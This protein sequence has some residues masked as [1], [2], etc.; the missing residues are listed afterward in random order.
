MI[1]VILGGITGYLAYDRLWANNPVWNSALEPS[2]ASSAVD[3]VS[4][5]CSTDG[6]LGTPPSNLTLWFVLGLRNGSGY[7]MD[8]RWN[9]TFY[10]KVANYYHSSS[11]RFHLAGNGDA[12][13]KFWTF[14][15][16]T[17]L[18]KWTSDNDL[19]DNLGATFRAVFNVTGV[20]G[21]YHFTRTGGVLGLNAPTGYL[22][23]TAVGDRPGGILAAPSCPASTITPGLPS[24]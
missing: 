23:S 6:Q 16:A 17:E 18:A 11:Q 13:P 12:Y 3:A 19:R 15:N 14:N 20:H 1:V 4:P 8:T 24:T 10:D 9:F 2:L 21:V 22:A 7:D 5:I